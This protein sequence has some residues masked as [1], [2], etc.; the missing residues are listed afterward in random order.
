MLLHFD[1]RWEMIWVA[2]FTNTVFAFKMTESSFKHP[3]ALLLENK[4]HKSKLCL[5][6]FHTMSYYNNIT[7]V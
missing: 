3:I 1:D 7:L 5:D 4:P 2:L 6:I